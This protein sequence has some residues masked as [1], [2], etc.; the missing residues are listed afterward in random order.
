MFRT[1]FVNGAERKES[2][3]VA[4]AVAETSQIT[5][6]ITLFELLAPKNIGKSQS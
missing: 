1:G 4:F 3:P 5:I 2:A 6:R